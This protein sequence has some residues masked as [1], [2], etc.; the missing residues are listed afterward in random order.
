M[1]KIDYIRG[2][3]ET[4]ETI[5]GDELTI[6]QKTNGELIDLVEDFQAE[7][8]GAKEVEMSEQSFVHVIQ[9]KPAKFLNQMVKEEIDRE[10]FLNNLMPND[11][12]NIVRAFKE[13]NFT[14]LRN[15]ITKKNQVLGTISQLTRNM[16]QENATKK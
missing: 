3:N 7:W 2:K 16:K 12:Y 11:I 14:F 4:Y 9:D 5:K 15:L 13:V 8:D 10:Y 1:N 6:E